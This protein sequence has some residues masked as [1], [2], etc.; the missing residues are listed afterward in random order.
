LFLLIIEPQTEPTVRVK[1]I[2]TIISFK[3]A[4]IFHSFTQMDQHMLCSIY[5]TTTSTNF[6]E[7]AVHGM[8]LLSTAVVRDSS[9]D[10]L[11]ISGFVDDVLF[12]IIGPM[13][14]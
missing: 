6:T 13:A 4:M 9:G 11:C 3:F 1:T 12:P 7:F 2:S 14:A 10:A 5:A 8:G